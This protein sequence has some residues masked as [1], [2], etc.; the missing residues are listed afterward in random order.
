MSYFGSD[1]GG[2]TGTP[3]DELY[4]R[5]FQFGAFCPVFRAHGVDSK[6]VAPYEFSSLVQE[7]CRNMLKLRYR[8]LPYIYTTAR[9]T[10]DTGLP[11]CRALTLAFP[12]DATMQND[13]SEFMF[14]SNILVAPVTV[15]GA[16]SRSMYLPAGKWIEHWSGQVLTGPV[17]TNWP[18]PLSRIPV[19]YR[20]NSITPLGPYVASSQFDDGT[21][22]ALRI[23]CDAT[24][25]YTLYDDDGI[26]TE[27]VSDDFATTAVSAATSGNAV[28]VNIGGAVGSY[29]GQPT[30]RAWSI[31]LYCTNT[32]FN[33]VAD[34]IVTDYNLDPAEK[35]LRIALPSAPVTQPHVVT[36]YLDAES[37][38]PF[39]ARVN[40]GGRPYLD[41]SG[42]LWQEDKAYSAGSF[43]FVGGT[44]GFI[45]N[46]IAG[47]SDDVLYQYERYGTNF[48]CQ[49]DAPNGLYEIKLLDADTYNSKPGD[50]LFNVFIEGQQ[51][52][53]NFDII[54][55]AGSNN[56]AITLTFT[57][58][59][60]DGQLDIRFTGGPGA[61]D[62]NARISAISVRK[63][64]DA[65]S[66]GDGIPDWWMLRYFGHAT[67]QAGD[68]SRAGDDADG[69]GVSNLNE[70]I[71]RTNPRD[72]SSALRV[73]T[74]HNGLGGFQINWPSV[75]GKK[76]RVFYSDDLQ[77]WTA[78]VPDKVADSTLSSWIDPAPL[79]A[80]RLYRVQALL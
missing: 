80:Q 21:Q 60:A 23:Y 15:Q 63:I 59:V 62:L 49:F 8:L 77:T 46:P 79:P 68:K 70:F 75:A 7:N 28:T 58:S 18:A 45:A 35:L 48:S 17:T 30:H 61:G 56:T 73:T 44:N 65:D 50:R 74:L 11:M 57:N 10:F 31:E 41:Q 34:G 6:P 5:W 53:T 38:A 26:S 4:V 39:G 12:S 67:G 76:Y 25:S 37:P 43:G 13:G 29:A 66:D 33:V 36:V 20:N 47:T 55:T 14:G 3:S 69:D 72:A 78:F 64:A 16:T 71:A 52:L 32:A 19:F 40:C 54:A 42:A 1:I 24:A 2:F 22:R 51:V 9:E 27:Y